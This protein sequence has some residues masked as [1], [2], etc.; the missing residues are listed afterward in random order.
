MNEVKSLN[1]RLAWREEHN[2][3]SFDAITLE[4]SGAI[5]RLYANS[6]LFT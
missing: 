3:I 1:H 2:G 4:N 5:S 6:G